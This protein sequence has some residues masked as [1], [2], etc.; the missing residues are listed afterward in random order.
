M[1]MSPSST[2]V[3]NHST[4]I[5]DSIHTTHNI[6]VGD[7]KAHNHLWGSVHTDSRGIDIETFMDS[8]NLCVL[9]DGSPTYQHHNGTTSQIDL[10][11]TSANQ[12]VYWLASVV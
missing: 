10:S 2:R 6:I 1:F 9:N 11:I 3:T 5:A 12:Y 4:E 8:N 7:I